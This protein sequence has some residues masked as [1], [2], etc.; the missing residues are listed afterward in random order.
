MDLTK[1]LEPFNS[2]VLYTY[3]NSD[4]Q[5]L[6]FLPQYSIILNTDERVQ[7]LLTDIRDNKPIAINDFNENWI[8]FIRGLENNKKTIH[9]NEK[10]ST[11]FKPT[12]VALSLT[13]RCH[14][15]CIYCYAKAGEV[16][17]D[18]DE[19]IIVS[20]LE[21]VAN[22]AKEINQG[23]INVVFHGQGEPTANWDLFVNAI[24][25]AK[26]IGSKQNL[27]V[28]FTMSTNGMWNKKQREFIVN[29]FKDLQI[30]LDGVSEVQDRQ[31]PTH[32]GKPSFSKVLDN[33]KYL[34]EQ[35]VTYGIRATILPDSIDQMKPFLEFI[36]NNTKCKNIHFEPFYSVGRAEDILI[37]KEFSNRFSEAFIEVFNLSAELGINVKYSGCFTSSKDSFCGATGKN[38][39]F[40]ITTDG[41]VSSCYETKDDST[42][43]GDFTIYG[44]FDKTEGKFNFSE[45]KLANLIEFRLSN[46]SNCTNCFLKWGCNGDCI[47]RCTINANN[48]GTLTF[49]P[50]PNRCDTNHKISLYNL[51]T[52]KPKIKL[53]ELPLTI[54]NSIGEKL[55]TLDGI[56]YILPI[57]NSIIDCNIV[58][59]GIHP[60]AEGNCVDRNCVGHACSCDG[61]QSCSCHSKPPCSHCFHCPHVPCAAAGNHGCKE[62]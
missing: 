26:E 6:M 61:K 41:I 22:N 7:T 29:N 49:T 56:K 2:D 54:E 8:N 17:K 57:D 19:N 12:Q 27:E 15:K 1:K 10:K 53:S 52:M 18:M 47:A 40:F 39:N 28:H 24:K 36:S 16:I 25:I 32:N 23:H 31:R 37:G 9:L 45:D 51:L 4:G 20:A 48:T 14:L 30:S 11:D 43:K 13:T 58:I 38:L 5:F 33:I 21:F 42:L 55:K 46:S 60:C 3:T 62:N 59:C 34:D 35:N 44:H 50:N